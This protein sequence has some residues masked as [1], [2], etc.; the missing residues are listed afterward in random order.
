[1]LYAARAYAF[2]MEVP[3]VMMAVYAKPSSGDL[4]SE[5]RRP[6]MNSESANSSSIFFR[7]S[8]IFYRACT[9]PGSISIWPRSRPTPKRWSRLL[10][11]P[12][13]RRTETLRQR[14]RHRR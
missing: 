7:S 14:L 2:P 3:P 4:P 10:A 8:L 13:G 12:P 11:A 6:R 9:R 5:M 1:M